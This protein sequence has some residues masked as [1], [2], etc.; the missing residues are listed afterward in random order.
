MTQKH[1]FLHLRER[2]VK[3]RKYNLHV[4]P[5]EPIVVQPLIIRDKPK[6]RQRKRKKVAEKKGQL[7]ITAIVVNYKTVNLVKKAVKSFR[8]YYPTIPLILIDNNSQDGSTDWAGRQRGKHTQVLIN[9]HN[10]GHGPALHQGIMQAKTRYVFTFDSDVVFNRGGFLEKM[11]EQ[12]IYAIGWLRFVNHN[13]VSSKS[14]NAV[15]LCPY[16]HPYAALY[17]RKIYLTLAPFNHKGAPCVANMHD[18]KKKEIQVASFPIE[19][20]VTHLVAGT[21]RM[22]KGH[23]DGTGIEPAIWN[24]KAQIPI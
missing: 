7:D 8:R 5:L 2:F 23:W 10:I 13:G 6:K 24:P 22:Y 19:N 14:K 18:A 4:I 1:S 17:D 12:K 16:I 3:A 9:N 20:Y 11:Q 21:R 15:W